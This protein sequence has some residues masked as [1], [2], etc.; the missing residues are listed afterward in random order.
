MQK[1]HGVLRCFLSDF[2]KM[3][4]R[5]FFIFI[6]L[7][8]GLV[9]A[10][11]VK[12]GVY[13]N[14]PKVSVDENGKP[15]GIFVDIIEEIA[16]REGWELQYVEGTWS[17][18]LQNLNDGSIDILSDVAYSSQRDSIMSF[19][20][21]PV[22]QSWVQ[23]FC[24]RQHQLNRVED[25]NGLKIGVLDGS[26]Q[27]YYLKNEIRHQ[28]DIEFTLICYPDYSSTVDAL[29]KEE[30]DALLASRFFFFSKLRTDNI[31]PTSIILHPG[32]LFF[33]TLKG[34]NLDKLNT[35]DLHLSQ[36]KND[37]NSMYYQSIQNWLNI[38]SMPVLSHSFKMVLLIIGMLFLSVLFF[39][40]ILRRRVR[41]KTQEL[42]I[43]NHKLEEKECNYREIFNTSRDAIYIHDFETGK[44]VDV[45]ETM[46]RMFGFSSKEE[47]LQ[48]L[49]IENVL[50]KESPESVRAKEKLNEA[51]EHDITFEFVTRKKNG[52][53][54][55]VEVSLRRTTIAGIERI[56]AFVRDIDDQKRIEEKATSASALFH[57][58]AMNSP[59]G[60]F[61]TDDK[62]ETIY[63]NP[64]W[65]EM[66]GLEINE[67]SG[68]AWLSIIHPED[69]E[70]TISDWFERVSNRQPS[71]AEYRIIKQDGRI[72]WVLGNAVPEYSSG[73]FIGYVGTVTDI[74]V[75]KEA[76]LRIQQQNLELIQAKEKAEES[77]RLKSSF[78]ANL[79][80]EIRTPMNAIVGF[81]G[82][83]GNAIN[84]PEES[85]KFIEII[86]QSS[87]QLLT[88]IDDIVQISLIETKQMSLNFESFTLES[89]FEHLS[90]MLLPIIPKSK[91]ITLQFEISGELK[92]KLIL[93]DR[94]K[95]EQVLS[96]LILNAI[97]F[98]SKGSVHVRC[99]EKG[100]SELYFEVEDTGVGIPIE[101]QELI[102]ER[103]YRSERAFEMNEK[104]SGLGLA[105]AKSYVEM[106][107][108][109]LNLR[110]KVDVG[111]VFFF[112]LPMNIDID[113]V[114]DIDEIS[115]IE[116]N[117]S[118]P[119]KVLV[120]DDEKMNLLF[121]EAAIKDL[122]SHIV[123]A[124]TGKDAIAM[125]HDDKEINLVLLDVRLPDM[126]GYDVAQEML[127]IKPDLKIII[128]T[129][130]AFP[131]DEEKALQVGCTAFIS[132]P[133]KIKK[134]HE[135]IQ[136][137]F[138][139]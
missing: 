82:L 103:F 54:F 132:K 93:T 50:E 84:N 40:V 49:D 6:V 20:K 87:H 34:E 110:S 55:W 101:E 112:T 122:S 98:T 38:E 45:N 13:D 89:V 66:T 118:A 17:E 121:L 133:I 108:G 57:T 115:D 100:E 28:F 1:V 59:V 104:G 85:Q 36:M 99:G 75:L 71:Q 136:F 79:S 9:N 77:N 111:S 23:V 102:F 65:C 44:V 39:I 107:G 24:L 19:H 124:E 120:V 14:P 68:T 27:E 72:V 21:I 37:P 123:K 8:I 128:Q 126:N 61:R 119:L 116:I 26:V 88:I 69:R 41:M 91:N 47:V 52:D 42:L 29:N 131:D 7:Q 138:R 92:A 90:S 109:I 51:K 31:V 64:R 95:L 58:L 76:E 105:I 67:I 22:I 25:L 62:G 2:L 63:V 60:I 18:Q 12:I 46:L 139:N 97:K 86:Q 83:L 3:G 43:L 35:V 74:S 53:K 96:N 11:I 30:I 4:F 113:G 80:H 32:D 129:A 48:L 135:T 56:L 33:A 137:C 16:D 10:Q 94:V 127:I 117:H 5:L 73:R 15:E 78:L 114:N 81:S 106:L 70:K 125:L 134:L 130:Y